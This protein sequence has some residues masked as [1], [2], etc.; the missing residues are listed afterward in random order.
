M[1]GE[2]NTAF[3]IALLLGLKSEKSTKEESDDIGHESVGEPNPSAAAV[4]SR[5]FEHGSETCSL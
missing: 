5:T 1:A 3:Y 2:G 4:R